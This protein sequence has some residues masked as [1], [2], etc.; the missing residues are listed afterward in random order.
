MDQQAQFRGAVRT[1]LTILLDDTRDHAERVQRATD[2]LLALPVPMPAA[3]AR[4]Q[5]PVEQNDTLYLAGP[6]GLPTDIEYMPEFGEG[7][8]SDEEVAIMLHVQREG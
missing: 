7:P 6:D 2:I 3:V 8:L 1:V 5:P 4:S